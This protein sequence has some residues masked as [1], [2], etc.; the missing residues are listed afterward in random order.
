MYRFPFDLD[1]TAGAA[2]A[3]TLHLR[4]GTV[5]TPVFMPVG[6]QGAIRALPPALLPSTNSQIILANTY[7][8]SQ[9]PGEHIVA[10]HGGL[11]RFMDVELPILTDSGGFQVFSL[12]KTVTEEG[13]DFAYEVDGKRT[14]LS[15]ERSM[16]IQ[17]AL[18]S[19][20]AMV[21]DEC[22]GFGTSEADAVLSVDR[23]ARWEGRSRAA[24]SRPD[25][26]LFGI[27]QGG[28][29]PRLRKR[30]AEQIRELDFDG[31]A[32][33]GLSVG[34]GHALMCEVLDHTM[35]HVP[36]DRPRY[37]MGVGRPV[38]LVEGVARGVDMFDCVIATRHARSGMLYTWQGRLRIT[39]RRY[40]NDMY[41]PDRQCGCPV[42]QKHTRAY[43]NHLFRVNEVLG[44]TL[45]TVHNLYWF[46]DFMDRMRGAVLD[47]PAAF[48]AFRRHVHEIHPVREGEAELDREEAPAEA[49]SPPAAGRPE[50][51]GPR[52]GPH[53]GG[54]RG[55]RGGG[56]SGPRR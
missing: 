35:P 40:R 46:S 32:I 42:C 55:G 53:G 52:G 26:S 15:P 27:V 8:L 39:D 34:E 12:Q 4:R 49:A 38:D 48:E 37:L 29:W 18:G 20:I 2:R 41:P 31:Y 43:L 3:T 10:K 56:R 19:D 5:R 23:T 54:G 45:T 11:H 1:G 17:Q 36:E 28:F 13:V 33:G 14:F 6:T 21:F 9:R 51:G 25:Q 24:H 16:E 7:H 44:A 50:R 22:L 30:S 47:G